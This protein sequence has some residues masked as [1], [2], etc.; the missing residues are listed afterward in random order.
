MV[1]LRTEIADINYIESGAGES[2]V[3]LHCSSSSLN[4]WRALCGQLEGRFRVLAPD[5]YGYG[6]SGPWAGNVENL[7]HDE[8]EMVRRL[9][10]SGASFHLVGH[11]YGGAIAL[12]LA[13]E[14]PSLLK[15]LVL[16]EPI[17]CW[18]LEEDK[19]D[20]PY[21]R[22]IT[23]IADTYETAMMRGD[24]D[25]ALTPYI[26]YWN[27]EGAWATMESELRNYI[28][29]TANKSAAEF[30]AI[31]DASNSVSELGSITV[32]TTIIRGGETRIP[33]RRIAEIVAGR[34][35]E[36]VFVT[37]PGAG[38]LSPIT[39]PELVNEAIH[40]HFGRIA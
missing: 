19:C 13:L 40:A 28:L 30:K 23:A 35:S 29:T 36:S 12:R 3:L 32:P 6:G 17:A 16:I 7:L 18:L 5:L 26:D 34:I 24:A 20:A 2:V 27:G 39:H 25:A 31:F 4:Q 9:A 38:H 22:E 33:A 21:Y 11:S 1:M 15:S 10:G 14:T 37:I 8:A